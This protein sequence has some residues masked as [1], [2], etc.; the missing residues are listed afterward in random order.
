MTALTLCSLR[1][2]A[3]PPGSIVV[4]PGVDS[5]LTG[6]YAGTAVAL[7]GLPANQRWG[8]ADGGVP[9]RAGSAAASWLR[10]LMA[11]LVKTLRRW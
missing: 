4:T 8:A 11:S 1:A 10:E 6:G 5:D 2:G 9:P 3:H 7:R